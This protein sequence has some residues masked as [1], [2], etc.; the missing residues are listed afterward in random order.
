MTEE[1]KCLRETCLSD[2]VCECGAKNRDH[3]AFVTTRFV[4]VEHAGGCPTMAR[5]IR[6]ARKEGKE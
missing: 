5:T 6:A 3:G 1:K 4:P 2:C